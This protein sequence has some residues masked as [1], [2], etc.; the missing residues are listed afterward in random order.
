[1]STKTNGPQGGSAVETSAVLPVDAGSLDLT[2]HAEE[3]RRRRLELAR[4]EERAEELLN[5][6]DLSSIDSDHEE[7]E[8]KPAI[9]SSLPQQ[10]VLSM[11]AT[12]L[13]LAQFSHP[14]AQQASL[15]EQGSLPTGGHQIRSTMA[16]PLSRR[17]K[18]VF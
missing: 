18:L 6:S 12:E 14:T 16:P 10:E 2:A 9:G 5:E 3:A 15:T 4:E 11:E 13:Y 8:G 7:R 17:T 1:M